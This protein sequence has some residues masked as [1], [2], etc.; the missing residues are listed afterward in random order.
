MVAFRGV[1]HMPVW[2]SLIIGTAA[3]ALPQFI[4]ALPHEVQGLAT[5]VMAMGTGIYHLYRPSPGSAVTP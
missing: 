5:A 3:T 2:F 1:R 4:N